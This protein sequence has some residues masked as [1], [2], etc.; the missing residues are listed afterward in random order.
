MA[1][2]QTVSYLRQRF[3]E[4]GI[5]PDARH[6][7]NFL[8]DMNLLRLLADA[9]ELGPRDVVLEVGTGTGALT[10]RMAERAAAVVTVE[11]DQ[12]L[13]QLASEVLID[14]ENVVMLHQDALK[15]KNRLHPRVI[16]AVQ[17]ALAAEPGR[18][19]K[20]AANLP[21]SVATPIL[22]N[23]LACETTPVSMTATI[24]K[25]LADRINARPST[26]DYSSLS[27]WM[28]AQ[29]DIEVVRVL[30]PQVFWPAPKVHSAIIKLTVNSEKR[31]R[32][33]D[34]TYFHQVV[35]MMFIHRRKFLRSNLLG[36]MKNRLSKPEV[37]E[38]MAQ[39]GFGPD[40]R[41]EQLDVETMLRLSEALRARAP[42]WKL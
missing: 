19:F 42:D 35:R 32:I 2:N 12:H 17:T 27:I 10:E 11:I 31:S 29:C 37:D 9:A 4:V 14:H 8:I 34:L 39:L 20:L 28:Q 6:G 21:Y 23:L 7:Q 18:Q 36:A 26:S 16:E 5:Q 30:P 1:R 22:T 33:P 13:H 25:E 41:A 40:T 3:A 38:V 24:Q 15:N